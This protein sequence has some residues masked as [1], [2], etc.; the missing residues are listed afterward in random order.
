M[1]EQNNVEKLS[2]RTRPARTL[3]QPGRGEHHRCCCTVHPGP[4]LAILRAIATEI[5]MRYRLLEAISD[6]P[7]HGET[8]YGLHIWVLVGPECSGAYHIRCLRSSQT[9]VLKIIMTWVVDAVQLGRA[10]AE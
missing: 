7:R 5:V 10:F 3:A 9:P 8:L 6:D 4:A 2:A 1:L